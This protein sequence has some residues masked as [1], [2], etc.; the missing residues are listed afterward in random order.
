LIAVQFC[1]TGSVG[2]AMR[3]EIFFG[4]R[5]IV[6]L[7]TI[8]LALYPLCS[9]RT[10]PPLPAVNLAEAGWR[11]QRGQAVWRSKRDGPE[12]AGELFIATQPDG[13]GLLQFTKTPLPLIVA[14][15]T[16]DAWQI[17]FVAEGKSWSGPGQPPERLAWL[18][19]LRCFRDIVPSAKWR[20]HPCDD[21]H[22]RLENNVTGEMLEGYL[23]PCP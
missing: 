2:R 7:F 8:S 9:C 15:T 13:R 10:V 18:Q 1:E 14:Q 4:Q 11:V 3:K 6:L 19:L 20:W 5:D 17:Q 16:P 21:G 12:I 22:W 23:T